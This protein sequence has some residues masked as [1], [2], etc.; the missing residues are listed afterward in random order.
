MGQGS[1]LAGN[2]MMAVRGA[3]AVLLVLCV[4]S[5]HAIYDVTRMRV[6]PFNCVKDGSA[7]SFPISAAPFPDDAAGIQFWGDWRVLNAEDDS[8]VGTGEIFLH[9]IM[10]FG[11]NVD[12]KRMLITGSSDERATFGPQLSG[13]YFLNTDG[14]TVSGSVLL[15]NYGA[16]R[17]VYVDYLIHY[18]RPELMPEEPRFAVSFYHA[19][20]IQVPMAPD[21]E[22]PESPPV[23]HHP[24]SRYSMPE[25]RTDFSWDIPCFIECP[26]GCKDGGKSYPALKSI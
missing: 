4:V 23:Y 15:V 19:I 14:L 16:P 22:D 11:G 8:V 5:V 2:D 13:R 10:L 26:T 12:K 24:V 17:T 20:T 6:G 25:S 9:H 18:T 7:E 3:V 21:V 1:A